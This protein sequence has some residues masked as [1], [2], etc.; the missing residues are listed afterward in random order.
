MIKEFRI[1]RKDT[2]QY[3]EWSEKAKGFVSGYSQI[4]F[5]T[6]LIYPEVYEIFQYTGMKDKNKNRICEGD[7]VKNDSWCTPRIGEVIY[8]EISMQYKIKISF[9]GT[10]FM[11]K[12]KHWNPRDTEI[13]CKKYEKIPTQEQKMFI[14]FDVPLNNKVQNANIKAVLPLDSNKLK[15][16]GF[17]SYDPKSYYY[18]KEIHED[19]TF[20]ISI[21]KESKEVQIDVLDENFCQPY[22]YQRA[23][24]NG[25]EK[26]IPIEI[27]KEVQKLMK[28]LLENEIIEGYILGDYI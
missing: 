5:D 20:N 4:V 27:H 3:F 7:I 6:A 17:T 1:Y 9:N 25:A 14:N 22:D 15:K 18:C 12:L 11:D 10:I 28:M 21:E 2:K 16:L 26:G 23:I 13:L 8:D 24:K 19:I